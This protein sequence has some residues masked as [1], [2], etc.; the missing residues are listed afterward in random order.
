V[1]E[2]HTHE[3]IGSV[4]GIAPGTSKSRLFDARRALR[5]R[6]GVVERGNADAGRA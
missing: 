5:A 6:L 1:V 2:G 3:E 4:L